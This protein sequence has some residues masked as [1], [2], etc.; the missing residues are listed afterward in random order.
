M[1]KILMIDDDA[2]F[3]GIASAHFTRLGYTMALAQDGKE[4][5]AKA[6]ALRPD[7]IVLDMMMPDMNGIEVLHELQATEETADVPVIVISGKY[8]DDGMNAIFAQERNF[9][10]FIS[11]P[12]S[13]S[14]LQEKVEALLKK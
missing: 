4:G 13:L 11:K 7:I 10:A 6:S 3:S 8:F 5:L 9:R 14:Q 2:D 1:F 12:V